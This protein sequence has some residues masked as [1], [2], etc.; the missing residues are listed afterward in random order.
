MKYS[1]QLLALLALPFGLIAPVAAPA[2]QTPPRAS[3]TQHVVLAGGCFWGMQLVFE[4]LTGVDRVVAG[5]S[6][7]NAAT[8]HYDIVSTGQTGQAESVEITYE[9]S[10]IS[11]D[12]L[13]RVYFMV[14]HD[15][16][17]RN[18]QGPDTGSQYRSAIFFATPQQAR[19]ARAAIAELK[20]RRAFDK[21]IVTQVVPLKA[22]YP[23]EAYHQDFALHNPADPYIVINDLPKVVRLRHE[24]PKLVR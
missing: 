21:P 23:A 18:Y 15:P 14:A 9:P 8:A 19:E 6:G 1:V 7:G 4:K 10:K 20:K 2:A 12:Q 24:F 13:L 22:F 5:Y 11:F 17:E 3:T 16:T